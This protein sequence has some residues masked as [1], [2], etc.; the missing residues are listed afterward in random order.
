M[1]TADS[2]SFSINLR[3]KK[4]PHQE[5]DQ[6]FFKPN[7]HV[8]N[9]NT[10]YVAT[11]YYYRISPWNPASSILR[12]ISQQAEQSFGIN[13][14]YNGLLYHN[15]H[16]VWIITKVALPKLKDIS[17]PDIAFDPDCPFVRNLKHSRTAARQVESI[18]SICRSMKPIISLMK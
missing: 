17:F 1:P 3:R 6:N 14:K 2:S 11:T 16:R 12:F 8:S 7:T 10:R 18:R 15:I 9:F 4:T 13:N 5:T